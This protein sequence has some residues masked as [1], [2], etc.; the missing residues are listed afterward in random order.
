MLVGAALLALVGCFGV[1][2]AVAA[3]VDARAEAAAEEAWPEQR[4]QI[5]A[6][7]ASVVLPLG[8]EPVE[9]ELGVGDRC[10][11][12]QRLPS[13]VTGEVVAALS[14]AG[15]ADVE[16]ECTEGPDVGS[17]PMGCAATGTVAERTVTIT[18]TR[19]LDAAATTRAEALAGTSSITLGGD[20]TA[21]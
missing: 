18:A 15:V 17:E 20:F 1:A 19:D 10:W 8:Y 11:R 13:E 3:A 21:P 16:H 14:S 7:V 5:E 12:V 9:C 6:A 4:R 2:A